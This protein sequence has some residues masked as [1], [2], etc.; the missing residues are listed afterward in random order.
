MNIFLSPIDYIV[1][2][3]YVIMLFFVGLYLDR[4][5]KSAADI[6]LGG[7][8]LKWWQIGFSI[9]S[10]NAG[11]MM[12]VGFASIGFTQGVVGSNFEW[13]AWAFLLLLG[14][15][16]IPHYLATKIS[17]MPQFLL[18]RYGKRSYNFLTIYSL[19]S[20]LV[21]WLGGSLY[22]G[23]LLISQIFEWPLLKA[24][25]IVA[26]IATSFTAI[27]G[28][29]AVVRVG[30][31]QSAIIILSSIILTFLALK[32]IGG[33][34]QLINGVPLSHWQLFRPASDPEYSWVA[35][36][37]GYPVVALYYWC[38]DQTIVQKVLAAKNIKQGQYGAFFIATLK[39]IM[40]FIFI[41]PGIMCFIL[42]KNITKPDNA[43][44][45]LVKQLMPHG[46]LG[47][48]IAALIAALIDTISSA[49]NSFS[50]V[51][52][53][54][55]VGR[56]KKLNE[57]GKQATGRIV[58]IAA[59]I[60]AIFIAVLYSK[61]GKGFFDLSQGLVSILAPPL[62][63]VFLAG[64]I[65]KKANNIAAET[66]LYG[67]GSICIILGACHVLNF[68]YKGYWPHFLLL[69]FYMFVFLAFVMII[70][71]LLTTP[72]SGTPLPSIAETSYRN[73]SES[74]KIWLLWSGLAAIMVIIYIVFNL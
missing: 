44:I 61:S 9:F 50:T 39:I 22:A 37:L 66:V 56:F 58:T 53:L 59:A 41:F 15:V 1:L 18:V 65:W 20:I 5:K 63:V 16:F 40:P 51:F 60:L 48:C 14:M 2:L 68:P 73:K 71:S 31:F 54:D 29:K 69:S 13:L 28:L 62:S 64:A 26:I 12:L 70:L 43:Y 72:L 36:I 55:V 30:I 57:R 4:K 32:K 67:G 10:A 74:K 46:L 25:I 27:G 3:C 21:V 52:T 7:K 23:G 38:T 33:I 42:F 11:P 34:R 35:I 6:F 49:L 24:M 45:T 17:T 47:L 19:I 8:S